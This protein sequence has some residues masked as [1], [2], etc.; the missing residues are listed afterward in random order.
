M[1][2]QDFDASNFY[3]INNLHKNGK[4]SINS[5]ST[6]DNVVLNIYNLSGSLVVSK[7]INLQEN[8]NQ[9]DFNSEFTT[10]IYVVEMISNNQK[11]T[12]K[13]IAD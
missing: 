7:N 13:V 3:S 8:E 2:N 1:K 6:F 12:Q 5:K 11:F 10:G 4:L 9:I